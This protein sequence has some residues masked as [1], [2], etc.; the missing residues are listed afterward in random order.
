MTPRQQIDALMNAVQNQPPDIEVPC[1]QNKTHWFTI[2]V[3]WE[4]DNTVVSTAD[5]EIY[6]G[7]AL[8]ANDMVA[9]GKYGEKKVPPGNYR[10]FFPN[11][12]DTEIIE[13]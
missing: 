9:K 11:I 12:H 2:L 3:R 1:K 6:R 10:I 4:D 13:G 8:H 5:F 7:E